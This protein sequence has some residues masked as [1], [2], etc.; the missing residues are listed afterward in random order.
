MKA[1]LDMKGKDTMVTHYL[2]ETLHDLK[3]NSYFEPGLR[4]ALLGLYWDIKRIDTGSKGKEDDLAFLTRSYHKAMIQRYIFRDT[5]STSLDDID[6]N[7]PE[8][9]DRVLR[10]RILVLLDLAVAHLDASVHELAW[11]FVEPEM[12]AN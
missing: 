6:R 8:E 5:V 1:T 7:Y 12:F 9:R 4:E 3:D 10:K 11:Q 2:I